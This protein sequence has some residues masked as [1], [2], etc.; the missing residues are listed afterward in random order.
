MARAGR[1]VLSVFVDAFGWELAQ[2]I[3][4]LDDVLTHKAALGTV[5]G[6]SSTCDPT[7]LT[8][9]APREHG[10]FSFFV[11]DPPHSPF[12]AL[13]P[14]GLLPSSVV[15]RGRVR[16]WISKW[17]GR[18]LG[19]NGYFQLY[20]VPWNVLPMMDY[21][22]K[23][24]IYFPGGILGGQKTVFDPLRERGIPFSLS[25]WRRPEVENLARLEHDVGEGRIALGWLFLASLDAVLHAQGTRGAAVVDRLRWYEERLRRI[26]AIAHERYEDVR[27]HVFSDHGM[28]DVKD[29]CDV[30]A[31]VD[32]TGLRFGH[33]YAAVYDS[34]TAR[35]WYLRDGARERIEAAMAGEPRGRWLDDET[36][37]AWGV[38][39]PGHRYGDRFWLADPGVLIVPS[40][41]GLKP[42]PG[43]HGYAPNDK[44]SVAFYGTNTP[45]APRPSGL[46]DLKG[47]VLSELGL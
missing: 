33:D 23:K 24:D 29:T 26:L 34:T 40:H 18:G 41:M 19:W 15:D 25:D 11:Y 21:I 31:R 13:R 12:A 35:F 17:V 22:E 9:V 5:F 44:D 45:D 4:F 1:L 43:M 3:P 46:A 38:D 10:H 8:G 14:M 7:I 16:S 27:I 47:V 2:R 30:M 39:F 20:N 28:T 42:I 32:A 37:H 36:L 6:Y